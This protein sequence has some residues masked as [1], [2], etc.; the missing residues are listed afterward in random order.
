MNMFIIFRQACASNL[1]MLPYILGGAAG[2]AAL[3]VAALRYMFPWLKYDIDFF[4]RAG[5][6]FKIEGKLEG[7][8]KIFIDLF[9]DKVQEHPNKP[10]LIFEVCCAF[11]EHMNIY[12]F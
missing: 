9:E 2:G 3:S 12:I 7:E 8:G 4:K 1:T 6:A 5:K 11:Q 10:F